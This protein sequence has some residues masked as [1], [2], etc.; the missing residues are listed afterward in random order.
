MFILLEIGVYFLI[1]YKYQKKNA[2]YYYIL[3]N[4]LLIPF[5]K[6]GAA[7]DFCMRASIPA[8]LILMVFV[9]DT[10]IEANQEKDWT[11]V[12]ML[13]LTLLIGS[14]TPIHE[15]GRTFRETIDRLYTE[16][17]VYEEPVEPYELLN[18]GNFSG[19]TDHSFFFKYIAK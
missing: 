17:Q 13:V 9:M 11:I 12:G 8:L 5:F 15:I 10:L 19:P 1:L 7:S 2:L 14:V 3:I 6:I 18:A 16:E 4:L